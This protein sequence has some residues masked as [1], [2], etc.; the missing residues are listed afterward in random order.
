MHIENAKMAPNMPP[1][2]QILMKQDN[3]QAKSKSVQC[4]LYLSSFLKY[5]TCNFD[6]LELRLFKVIR[7]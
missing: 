4:C 6:D 7:G 3:V 1:K 5:L 2:Q